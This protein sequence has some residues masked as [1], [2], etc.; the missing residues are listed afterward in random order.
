MRFTIEVTTRLAF[1]HA[2]DTINGQQ[3]KRLDDLDPVFPQISRRID[4]AFPYW[5]IFTLTP[6][7]LR[8]RLRPR[9]PTAASATAS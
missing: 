6:T 4:A 9:A 3:S 7:N 8:I 2:T 5:R 1:S